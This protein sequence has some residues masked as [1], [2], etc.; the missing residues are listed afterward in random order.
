MSASKPH[1]SLTFWLTRAL[2][3]AGVALQV[4]IVL[5]Q[6][7]GGFLRPLFSDARHEPNIDFFTL[8]EAGQRVWHGADAF[9]GSP[10]VPRAT[11]FD[12]VSG[13]RYPPAAAYLFGLPARALGGPETAG[14][15]W[16]V[17]LRAM[18]AAALWA[19][20]RSLKICRAGGSPSM[21]REQVSATTNKNDLFFFIAGMWLCFPPYVVEFQLGQFSLLMALFLLLAYLGWREGRLGRAAMF[22]GLSL[23]L[24]TWSVLFIPFLW[25]TGRRRTAI[26]GVAGLALATVPYFL[27]H[28]EGWAH[29]RAINTSAPQLLDWK[30]YVSSVG[31]PTLYAA[32]M[33]D[34]VRGPALGTVGGMTLA[35]GHLIGW[36]IT[37][38]LLLGALW[39]TWKSNLCVNPKREP[40]KSDELELKSEIRNPKSEI[41]RRELALLFALWSTAF[42]IIYRD[43]WENHYIM[44]LPALT[45]LALDGG[46]RWRWIAL[47]WFLIAA[48]TPYALWL[49]AP[50]DAPPPSALFEDGWTA[51]QRIV[52][53]AI[54]PAGVLV[55]YVFSFGG[56]FKVQGSKFK[57]VA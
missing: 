17:M 57:E 31:F 44:L 21:T 11:P 18:I 20:W 50:F 26:F 54:R 52:Y 42:F 25:L 13:M 47:A 27:L 39:A 8:Y 48:P 16:Q 34:L 56:L 29:F 53:H 19:V 22:W 51:G 24:K 46:V 6:A 5:S 10:D 33:G 4:C 40:D 14:A 37:G 12:Y 45:A 7:G 36:A 35:P 2:L 32:A 3:A 49:D 9:T 41:S 43:V 30:T 1:Q 23:L 28:P 38:A 55:V 15:L